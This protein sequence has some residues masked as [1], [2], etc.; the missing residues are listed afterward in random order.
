MLQCEGLDYATENWNNVNIS[1]LLYL[2]QN[3]ISRKTV[4][5]YNF[6]NLKTDVLFC[7]YFTIVK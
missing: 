7:I 6:A 1:H 5:A 4:L 3:H 2:F